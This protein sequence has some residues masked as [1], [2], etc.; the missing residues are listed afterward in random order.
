[1][2]KGQIMSHYEQASVFQIPSGDWT[3]NN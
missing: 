1:M 3:K 2:Q